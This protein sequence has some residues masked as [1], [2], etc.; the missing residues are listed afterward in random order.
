MNDY[1]TYDVDLSSGMLLILTSTFAESVLRNC[2]VVS[3]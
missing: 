1:S 3:E 2:A